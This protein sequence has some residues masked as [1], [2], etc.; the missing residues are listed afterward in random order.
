MGRPKKYANAAEKARAYRERVKSGR[1]ELATQPD[2]IQAMIHALPDGY[3]HW[4]RFV[5]RW[6]NE[7]AAFARD[8]YFVC[9]P[10]AGHYAWFTCSSEHP[11]KDS[12][13]PVM[14]KS[15]VLWM[16]ESGRIKEVRSVQKMWTYYR[17]VTRD[18][19]AEALPHA[20]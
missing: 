1:S 11:S 18:E 7:L 4:C 14:F 2:A 13:I 8:G 19:K 12:S 9:K 16:I 15:T 17:I 6:D 10:E 5:A 20:D 3:E